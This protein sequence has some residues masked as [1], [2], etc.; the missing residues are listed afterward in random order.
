MQKTIFPSV[1][2]SGYLSGETAFEDA[3]ARASADPDFVAAFEANV[4]GPIL[5]V[6]QDPALAGHFLLLGSSDR[7]DTAGLGREDIRAQER[8]ASRARARSASDGIFALANARLGGALGD[9]WATVPNIGELSQGIG[10]ALLLHT[11]AQL[12]DAQRQENRRIHC[13][14]VRFS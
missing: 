10:A 13:Q 5:E 7:V 14:F 11:D 4:L 2:M 9:S 1:D 6:A 3:F 8:E 12:S